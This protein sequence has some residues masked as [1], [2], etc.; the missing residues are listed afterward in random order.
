MK[1]DSKAPRVAD[2]PPAWLMIV[3]LAIPAALF[4]LYRQPDYRD[5]PEFPAY[6]SPPILVVL[7]YFVLF[8][9]G[10]FALHYRIVAALAGKS[11]SSI[12]ALNVLLPF[13]AVIAVSALSNTGSI[14]AAVISLF[15]IPIT[16]P[17][18]RAYA[19]PCAP[20]P[21]LAFY[22]LLGA[23]HVTFDPLILTLVTSGGGGIVS[24][25]FGQFSPAPLL[26][27]GVAFL[28]LFLLRFM[29]WHLRAGRYL[30]PSHLPRIG[31]SKKGMTLIELLIVIAVMSIATT[32]VLH[33][34][35]T[36]N[37]AMARQ[38]DW[39]R[40]VNLADD[41]IALLRSLDFLPEIGTH[42]FERQLIESSPIAKQ[43]EIDV[44]PGPSESL[45][46]VRVSVH[47][48]GDASDRDVTLAVILPIHPRA[49]A[50]L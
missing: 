16:M 44:R 39:R 35:M 49:G 29:P 43:G 41:E 48:R 14:S 47:L 18:A 33:S 37:R 5:Q 40:A 1:K 28:L 26:V 19:T 4:L 31:R 7:T 12:N 9:V 46:E 45:R 8:Y 32:G 15:L 21:L 34:M 27:Y 6:L 17:R 38:Q 22:V 36:V 3:L 23:A 20:Y 50:A 25:V 13:I 10:F 11:R 30:W 42:P 24:L 2:V